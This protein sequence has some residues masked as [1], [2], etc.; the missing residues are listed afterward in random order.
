MKR[1]AGFT[2]VEILVVL[3]I[4]AILAAL[5]F[6]AFK[7]AQEKGY[8]GS[9]AA[10]LHQIGMAVNT[11][12]TEE[13]SYPSSLG[14]LLPEDA[15]LNNL[16]GTSTPSPTPLPNTNGTGLLRLPQASLVCPDDDT[17]STV[18]RATYGDLSNNINAGANT[19]MARYVW[20]YWG[21]K[22]DG[23]AYTTPAAAA[24]A[25]WPPGSPTP[26]QSVLDLLTDPSRSYNEASITGYDSTQPFNGMKYS[27]SNRYAPA[28]TIITHC[29]YHRL[30]TSNL[31]LASDVYVPAESENAKGAKDIILRLDGSARAFDITEFNTSKWQK[32]NF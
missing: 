21:Y 23:T 25:T 3:A 18:P 32:Q 29:I 17:E 5:L 7:A 2:L 11:Y 8:Q 31:A 26:A 9:C 28:T 15:E 6:P 27:L 19:D 16:G 4:I 14:F 1:R 22:T 10:T 20:N 13:G 24:A 30:P 12:K